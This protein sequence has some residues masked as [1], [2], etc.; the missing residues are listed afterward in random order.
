MAKSPECHLRTLVDFLLGYYILIRGGDWRSIEISDL[1]TF[2]FPGKGPTPY[3]PLIL[4]IRAGKQ[5]Q[6]G[7]LKTAGALRSRDP[8]IY[9]LG[10]VGFYLL[11]Q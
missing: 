2:E 9:I 1:F 11:Y 6:Y 8:S 5:N 3:I 7:R 10:A 4:T